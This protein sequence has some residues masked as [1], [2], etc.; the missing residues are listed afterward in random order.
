MTRRA[1]R[2]A[3]D[4]PVR[5]VA[6]RRGNGVWSAIHDRAPWTPASL[7]WDGDVTNTGPTRPASSPRPAD[8]RWSTSLHGH[9]EVVGAFTLALDD[10]DGHRY[11][12]VVMANRPA[13]SPT[14]SPSE[15][16]PRSTRRTACPAGSACSPPRSAP[17]VRGRGRCGGPAAT[18]RASAPSATAGADVAS[19]DA[20]SLAFV[21][22]HEPRPRRPGST[23][24]T[25]GRGCRAFRSS[26]APARRRDGS[27]SCA[28]AIRR[29]A[30]R[31]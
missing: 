17:A 18:S 23:R 6:G 30:R 19:I 25:G 11:R 9:V 3:G 12:S 1:V 14:S 21:R 15:R 20:L 24:S 2:L 13:R 26:C 10:A 28:A 29:R 8:G 16:S 27:T 4:V 22:R 7:R 31:T 5:A